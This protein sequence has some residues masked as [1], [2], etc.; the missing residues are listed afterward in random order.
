MAD[1]ITTLEAA[2][3]DMM[4]AGEGLVRHYAGEPEVGMRFVISFTK[5]H[6]RADRALTQTEA[7]DTE[8]N[9]HD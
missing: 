8:E 7:P 3:R 4:D 9:P 6:N 5:A 2:L 1:R